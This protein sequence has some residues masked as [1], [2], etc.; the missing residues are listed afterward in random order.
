ML[1]ILLCIRFFFGAKRRKK[2]RRK[3]KRF[4][5]VTVTVA[6]RYLVPA[7]ACAFL[8]CDPNPIGNLTVRVY[9]E[10]ISGSPHPC[11]FGNYFSS[12]YKN[13]TVCFMW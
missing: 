3:S 5:L 1:C 6:S 13:S 4:K 9:G 2:I 7:R 8:R 12:F 10:L 11:N